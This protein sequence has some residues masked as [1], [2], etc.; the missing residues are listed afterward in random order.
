MQQDMH[1]YGTY[2]MARAAGVKDD[3][4]RAIATAAEY[5]DDSDYVSVTLTDGKQINAVPTAHHPSAVKANVDTIDQRRT[6]VPFHFIPGND[7]ANFEER[8]VCRTDS[9]IAREMVAHNISLAKE[10]YGAL[11]AGIT[12]HVYA[13]T[14]SHYGFLGLSSELNL[15]NN[16]TIKLEVNDRNVFD[17]ITRKATDFAGKYLKGD[18]HKLVRLGHGSVATYPDR[19]FLH[20]SF[21]YETNGRDSGARRNQ[22]TF[23]QA[24]HMLHD[25]FTRFA[26]QFRD[27]FYDAASRR[28]FDAISGTVSRVLAVE[29]DMEGRIA[30]WQEAVVAGEI[31]NNPTRR[32]IPEYDTSQFKSELEALDTYD[33]AKADRTLVF[34]FLKAADVHRNYV[35]GELLP[36]H[37]LVFA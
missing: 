20:W 25:M 27:G 11:L 18:F 35:L 23:L 12:A 17:Y 32:P 4:A 30:A 7:G 6:W 5:V 24:C 26:N 31:Y 1:Y 9:T 36:K 21:K 33:S 3:V 34:L 16:T 10:P 13:D 28:E 15:V 29:A 14:F 19:P 22:E 8:L 37:K 2:A